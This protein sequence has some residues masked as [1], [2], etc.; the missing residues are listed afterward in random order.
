M[1]EKII[2]IIL[3]TY[4]AENIFKNFEKNKE[5]K[6]VVLS[7]STCFGT[8]PIGKMCIFGIVDKKMDP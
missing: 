2:H 4:G 1:M 7:A 6:T 8:K 3:V 5:G